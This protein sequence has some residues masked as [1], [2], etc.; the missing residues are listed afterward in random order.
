MG[1]FSRLQ[2]ITSSHM[3]SLQPINCVI[4]HPASWQWYI[5]FCIDSSAFVKYN[6]RSRYW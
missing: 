6:V 4:L 1:I 5:A 3:N 2:G